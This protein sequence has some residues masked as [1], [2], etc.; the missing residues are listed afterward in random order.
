MTVI[1]EGLALVVA[2]PQAA[3]AVDLDPDPDR[4]NALLARSAD[5]TWVSYSILKLFPKSITLLLKLKQ[6]ER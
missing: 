1:V 2:L 5:R 6:E 4:R 3:S